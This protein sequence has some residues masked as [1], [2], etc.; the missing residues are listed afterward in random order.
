ME[1]RTCGAPALI[2]ADHSREALGDLAAPCSLTAGHSGDHGNGLARWEA[3]PAKPRSLGTDP[4]SGKTIYAVTEPGGAL[5]RLADETAVMAAATL[6]GVMDDVLE[7]GEATEAEL[8]AFV[9]VLVESLSEVTE[10]AARTIDRIPLDEPEYGPAAR[11]LRD[12]LRCP[13]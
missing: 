3:S 4:N 11:A 10:V 2:P 9:P 8:A 13:R 12:A 6:L 5:E 7:A 1:N